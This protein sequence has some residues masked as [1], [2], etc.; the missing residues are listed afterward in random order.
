LASDISI[1]NVLAVAN[2]RLVR[3]YVQ[4][5]DRL[6][7]L[8][9]CVK[10][11]ARRRGIN[12][13]SRGTLSSFALTLMLVHFLQRRQPPVLPSLQDL[14]SALGYPPVFI[15]GADCRYCSSQQGITEEL[16]RLCADKP[17]NQ[18]SVGLLLREF[19]RY[20]G[21]EYKNGTIAIRNRAS[22]AP[23]EDE[24]TC[25]L[26]VDN[27]FEPGTD[28][29]NVEVRLYTRLREEFRRA[30]ALLSD[31]CGLEEAFAPPPSVFGLS[32]LAHPL[33]PGVNAPLGAT[34]RP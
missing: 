4:A 23:A 16:E 29:A 25:Y 34:F 8:A 12:D 15:K 13:R 6:R 26:R 28:V 20:F 17:P 32:P 30:H 11:W 33:Q 27:P 3:Q 5:D 1:N 22:F 10:T 18:E 9:L 21:Y 14:A 7:Q 24:D 2:S 31:G 19:F